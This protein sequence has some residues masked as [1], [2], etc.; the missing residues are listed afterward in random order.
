MR[1]NSETLQTWNSQHNRR[2]P[3]TLEPPLD[4]LVPPRQLSGPEPCS[5][6]LF[7]AFITSGPQLSRMWEVCLPLEP[8]GSQ[9][10]MWSL[11]GGASLLGGHSSKAAVLGD[12][13]EQVWEEGRGSTRI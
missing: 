13:N 7:T 9:K 11:L 3:H 5:P 10:P 6:E 2:V 4:S 12:E 1:G 8:Q